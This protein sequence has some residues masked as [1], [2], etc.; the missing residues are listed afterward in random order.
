MKQ[1]REEIIR[2]LRKKGLKAKIPQRVIKPFSEVIE[3]YLTSTE[4]GVLQSDNQHPQYISE[5]Y[6]PCIKS[7]IRDQL[8]IGIKYLPRGYLATGW[9]RALEK[10]GTRNCS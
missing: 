7:A 5:C 8:A 10:L 9:L 1:K 6:E 2:D 4:P 3:T